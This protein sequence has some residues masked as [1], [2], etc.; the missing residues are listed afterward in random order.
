MSA[1]ALKRQNSKRALVAAYEEFVRDPATVNALFQRVRHFALTKVRHLEHDLKGTGT[2][3]TPD[4]WAQNIALSVWRVL[5]TFKGS[6][7]EFYSWIHK[8]CFNEATDVFNAAT[9][10]TKTSIS[11]SSRLSLYVNDH[12]DDQEERLHPEVN[13]EVSQR[14]WRGRIPESIQGVDRRI[15]QLLMGGN[16]YTEVAYH[17]NMTESAIK[18]RVKR[19]RDRIR[20]EQGHPSLLV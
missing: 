18:Q 7:E 2:D 5:P 20:K 13:Q 1:E 15:C 9:N 6:G 10:S 11:R 17:L 14:E 8:V 16:R 4:D 3:D 19:L 12:T